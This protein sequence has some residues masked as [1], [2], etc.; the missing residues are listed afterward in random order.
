MSQQHNYEE[1]LQYVNT[2]SKPSELRIT[3]MR[4]ANLAGAPYPCEILKLYTNQGIVGFGEVR[5][6]AS[7]TYALMLKGRIQGGHAELS[8]RL[9][10]GAGGLFEKGERD[11]SAGLGRRL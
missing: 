1:T 2:C 9:H 8:H 7:K 3:D 10:G 11:V 4:F 6:M 5:D